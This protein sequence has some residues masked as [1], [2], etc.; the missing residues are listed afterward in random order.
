MDADEGKEEGGGGSGEGYVV[1][2]RKWRPATFDQVVGQEHVTRTLKNALSSGRVAHAYLFTGPRGVGKTTVARVLAK[3]LNCA[4]AP[5]VNPCGKCSSCIEIAQ[6]SSMDV[7]EIDGA[8]NRGIDEIRNLRE[9]VRYAPVGG[10]KKVYIIDEVHMLTTE[11]FNALLKTLEEPPPHVVFVFATTQPLKVLGTIT[12]RCQRFDFRRI[13]AAEIAARLAE[14][15]KG[16]G[17]TCEPGALALISQQADGSMR[18]AQSM[19]EQV[20]AF[21]GGTAT[22][23]DIRPIMGLRG[24]EM[25]SRIGGAIVGGDQRQVMEILGEAFDAGVDPL[26]LVASLTEWTRNLLVTSIDPDSRELQALSPEARRELTEAAAALSS[27]HLLCVLSMLAEAED[28]LKRATHQRYLLESVILRITRIKSVARVSDLIKVLDGMGGAKAAPGGGA[29]EATR[30][31]VPP[32]EGARRGG[33]SGSPGKGP[34]RPPDREAAGGAAARS[35][36]TGDSASATAQAGDRAQAS[37]YAG[38][39]MLGAAVDPVK[40]WQEVV[41]SLRETKASLA[42]ILDLCE[43]P[44]SYDGALWLALPSAFHQSQ[45]LK[46][47]NFRMLTRKIQELTNTTV[48]LKTRIA[49]AN[50]EK[51]SQDSSQLDAIADRHPIVKALIHNFGGKIVDVRRDRQRGPGGGQSS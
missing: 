2:A 10:K 51:A 36:T 24:S 13:S 7:V 34:D 14:I 25:L 15:C 28:S 1:I 47:D 26:D 30:R 33:G 23:A 35:A 37:D 8:S 40:A 29:R 39:A 19:L 45:I 17:H 20:L 12:S 9:S 46:G 50:A 22:E 18:D 16:D 43:P 3:S 5:T 27:E 41:E 42:S 38:A 4:E 49:D 48:V 21:S 11:A 44:C 6:G 31:A 32:T